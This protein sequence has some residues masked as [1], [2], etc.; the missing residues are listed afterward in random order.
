MVERQPSWDKYEAAILLEGLLASMK[1]E[2]TRSAAI[3]VVSRD[4][5]EMALHRGVEIDEVYRN[6]NGISFQMKSMES[7][8]LGYTVFKPATKLFA[9]VAGLYHGSYDEYQKLEMGKKDRLKQSVA[10]RF[11]QAGADICVNNLKELTEYILYADK[12]QE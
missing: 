10:L 4:L 11:Q 1:G 8:Y 7:A 5:R 6:A 3:K 2:L 12:N 9:A